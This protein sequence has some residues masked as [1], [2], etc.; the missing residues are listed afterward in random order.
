[1]T[2]V[3]KNIIEIKTNKISVMNHELKRCQDKP[4]TF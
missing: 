1:M 2:A 3:T 4:D